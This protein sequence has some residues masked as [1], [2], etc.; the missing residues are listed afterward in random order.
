[1]GGERFWGVAR[2]CLHGAS[3]VITAWALV[4]TSAPERP[5]VPARDCFTG[6]P[7][8]PNLQVNLASGSD[9]GAAPDGGGDDGAADASA[10]AVGDASDDGSSETGA[11]SDDAPFEAS[12]AGQEGGTEGGQDAGGGDEGS[13]VGSCY[14]DPALSDAACALSCNG[15]DGLTPGTVLTFN[16]EKGSRPESYKQY[17]F[18]YTT[19]G[20]R[21]GLAGVTFG[22]L[23]SGP[24][25]RKSVV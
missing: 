7:A 1:M 6:L 8:S 5:L 18:G 23:P 11:A 24:Q 20:L 4:A 2:G 25:D 19:V 15:V 3:L 17:C 21:G 16:L 9:G 13:A 22:L 10:D 12:D 14:L